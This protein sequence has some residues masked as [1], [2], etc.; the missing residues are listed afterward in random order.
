LKPVLESLRPGERILL[1]RWYW[2]W[3][4][5]GQAAWVRRRRGRWTLT[6]QRLIARK[7]FISK[8]MIELPLGRIQDVTLHC[9]LFGCCSMLVSSAGGPTPL[10]GHTYAR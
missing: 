4:S 10:L 6:D 3:C 8:S 2:R 7:G 9:P 5:G 1:D